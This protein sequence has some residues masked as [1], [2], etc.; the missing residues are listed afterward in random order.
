M[1]NS[2]YHSA[3]YG[4]YW[5]TETLQYEDIKTEVLFASGNGG[6]Y[7]MI[8]PEYDAKVVFTGSNYGNWR[9]KLPFEMLLKYIIPMLQ[10]SSCK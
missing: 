10:G 8:L 1:A 5:Y 2:K 4:F 3:T 7:M 9:G 6:Q